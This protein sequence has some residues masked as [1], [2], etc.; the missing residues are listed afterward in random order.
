MLIQDE[1]SHVS[2]Q[3]VTWQAHTAAEIQLQ[4][5][6]ATLLQAGRRLGVRVLA[7][8]G[9]TLAVEAANPPPPQRQNPKVKRLVLRVPAGTQLRI[10]LL[11][12]PGGNDA[13]PPPKLEPLAAWAGQQRDQR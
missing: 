11:F 1:L 9:G 2:G 7:P 13:A 3:Q 12:T 8:A 10:A 4:G 5:D 6:C